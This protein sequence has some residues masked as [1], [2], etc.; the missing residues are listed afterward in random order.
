MKHYDKRDKNAY[1]FGFSDPLKTLEADVIRLLAE[2]FSVSTVARSLKISDM[3]VT[4]I[5]LRLIKK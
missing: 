5:K 2:G 1:R 4:R 3:E